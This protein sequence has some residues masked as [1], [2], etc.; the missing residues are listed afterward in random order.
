MMLKYLF[1][2][3]MTFSFNAAAFE[4]YQNNLFSFLFFDCLGVSER[5]DIILFL[6]KYTQGGTFRSVL[7]YLLIYLSYS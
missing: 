7:S 6:L 1:F 4:S 2:I 3:N 5:S